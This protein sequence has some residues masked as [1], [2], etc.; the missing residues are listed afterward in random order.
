M[1]REKGEQ[2]LLDSGERH[3][4]YLSSVVANTHVRLLS[5]GHMRSGEICEY[6]DLCDRKTDIGNI[7]S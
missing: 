4:R 7:I 5:I 2:T 3:V 1:F 6:I